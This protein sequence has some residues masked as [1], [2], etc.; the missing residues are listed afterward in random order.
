MLSPITV[1]PRNESRLANF[2]GKQNLIYHSPTNITLAATIPTVGDALLALEDLCSELNTTLKQIADI[3]AELTNRDHIGLENVQEVL[4]DFDPSL[5]RTFD[6][7]QKRALLAQ[8][9]A[10]AL[11]TVKSSIK[12]TFDTLEMLLLVVWRH[13]DYYADENRMSVPP[14]HATFG[15]ALRL[16]AAA[17]PESFRKEVAHKIGGTLGWLNAIASVSLAC[18]IRCQSPECTRLG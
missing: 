17:E 14:A 11:N 6:L 4:R 5:L 1:T 15:N 10:S 2:T 3:N 18:F 12:V 16:L 7:D 8:S 13:L 9:L